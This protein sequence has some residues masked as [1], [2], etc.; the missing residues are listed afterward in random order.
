M[1]ARWAND[2]GQAFPIYVV[3]IAALLFAALAFFVVGMAGATRSDAQGAADAA[4]LAGAQEARDNLFV[5]LSVLDLKPEDW[6]KLVGGDLLKSN[7]ACAKAREFAGLN[8]AAAECNAPIPVVT[9]SVTTTRTV[10]K[11]VVPGSEGLPGKATAKARIEP[12]CSLRSAP[13]PDPAPTPTSTSTPSPTTSPVSVGVT[14][15]CKG[16]TITVDPAH[17]GP[18]KQLARALFNVRLVD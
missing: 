17:P 10:G 16:K 3:V 7:G 2:R 18:L 11:S 13:A 6:G 8:N 4:A 14:L 1:S 15:V 12:R 5:G 9:V